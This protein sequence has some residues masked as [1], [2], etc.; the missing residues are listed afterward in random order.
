MAFP[1]S[2]PFVSAGSINRRNLHNN[3]VVP[4]PHSY[5]DFRPVPY[6]GASPVGRPGMV[7]P[8][9]YANREV[10]AP[11]GVPVS[12]DKKSKKE[13]KEKKEKKRKRDSIDSGQSFHTATA[14]VSA[15][16]SQGPSTRRVYDRHS[17]IR[18]YSKCSSMEENNASADEY[19]VATAL[20]RQSYIRKYSKRSSMGSA[21]DENNATALNRQPSQNSIS[22]QDV[23]RSHIQSEKDGESSCSDTH[24]SISHPAHIE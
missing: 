18:K 20:N 10:S 1:P 4:P 5:S 9:G 21:T 12:K 16:D 11:V 15:S 2:G 13:K 17:I 19:I 22:F 3:E 14:S 23:V 8:N 7:P 6:D 24:P